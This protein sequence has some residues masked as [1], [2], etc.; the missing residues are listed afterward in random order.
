MW[1]K[2]GRAC[3]ELFRATQGAEAQLIPSYRHTSCRLWAQPLILT[4]GLWAGVQS[5][6]E[7]GLELSVPSTL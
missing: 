4:Q 3:G 7:A 2:E 1:G 6:Q 5:L